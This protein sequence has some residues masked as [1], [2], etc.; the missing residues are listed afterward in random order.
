MADE[1]MRKKKEKSHISEE[2]NEDVNK[3]GSGIII[4]FKNT[5]SILFI[6]I[7]IYQIFIKRA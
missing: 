6:S 7:R 4:Y 1:R 3:Q 2:N 5:S